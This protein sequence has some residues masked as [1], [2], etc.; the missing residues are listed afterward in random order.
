MLLVMQQGNRRLADVGALET[1]RRAIRRCHGIS[2][3]GM[4]GGF[5]W[6]L[7]RTPPVASCLSM[8]RERMKG[9]SGVS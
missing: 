4:G 1:W 5:V 3:I 2:R 7:A 8:D 6:M 9:V